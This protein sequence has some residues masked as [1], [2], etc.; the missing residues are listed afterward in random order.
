MAI[1]EK[2]CDPATNASA[3]PLR[4]ALRLAASKQE[5]SLISVTDNRIAI[6]VMAW[7]GDNGTMPVNQA[8]ERLKSKSGPKRNDETVLAAA[9]FIRKNPGH[10]GAVIAKAIDVT[11]EHFRSR[12]FPKLKAQGF[13][14][15]DGYRPPK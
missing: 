5:P 15:D 14:N 11:P 7:L 1:N 9:K 3:D 13:Y 4:R 6:A 8:I 2:S 12:V 10:K